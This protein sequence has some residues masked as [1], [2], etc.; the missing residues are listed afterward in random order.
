MTVSA[1]GTAMRPAIIGEVV[2]MPNKSTYLVKDDQTQQIVTVHD[3][4]IYWFATRD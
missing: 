2:D 4:E 3:D 1:A